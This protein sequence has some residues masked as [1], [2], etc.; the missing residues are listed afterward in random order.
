MSDESTPWK[1]VA[2]VVALLTI[3]VPACVAYD[4]YGRGPIPEKRMEL[5]QLTPINP[6]GDLSALGDKATFSLRIEKQ[7]INLR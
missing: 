4:I 1:I 2:I 7:T 3:A 6:L 5:R